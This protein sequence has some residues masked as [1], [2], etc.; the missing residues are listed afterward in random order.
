[1]KVSISLF[2]CLLIG[3][4]I[5]T[6][7]QQTISDLPR[8]CATMEQD[9][10]NKILYPQ[11]NTLDDFEESIQQRMK[12]ILTREKASGRTQALV[13]TIPVVVHVIHNGEAVGSGMNLSKAQIQSQIDVLNEDFRRRAGTPGF[14]NNPVGADIEIEFCLSPVDANG[15]ALTDPGIHRY[16]GNKTSWTREEIEGS[17]K[18]STTWNSNLF[19]N[20]WTV[21]FGG[22]SSNL[23]GYAQFPDQSGL[24]G[25]NET[26][27]SASTDGVVIQYTSF[28]SVDKGSFPIMQAPYNK[29][30]TL[31]HETGHWLGL[32]H[33]WGDGNC[34]DDFVSDTPPAASASTGCNVGRFSCGATNMV[35]N[36]MDYSNDACMNI[37]TLGQK[38]RIRAVMDLS[39]RRKSLLAANLCSPIVADVPTPDFSTENLKCV[40]LGSRVTFTDLSTNFPSE[41][42]WTFEGGD[43]GTST[44]R[45]P[46]VR[47]NSIGSFKVSL[48]AKNSL[49]ISDTL[50]V[51]DYIVVSEQGLCRDINNFKPENT[52]S[53]I[54]LAEFG[55]YTGYLTG[56]N[57]AKSKG[58][59]EFFINECGYKYISG[60]NIRFGH[61]YATSEDATV[62][63]FVWNALGPQRAPGAVIER[64]VI[65]LKQIQ[66][67]LA[68][69]K[70]TEI[71]FDRETPVFS[72]PYQVGLE[73]NYDDGD[74]LAIQ[75]S[76]DG[77]S[78]NATSWIK[79][80]ASVWSTYTIAF[81][82]N[83]AMDIEPVIGMNPSVQV[84]ASKQL[85]Y[86]GEE[87][88]LN[89]RGASIFVWNTDDG[90][91][92]NYSGPQ[93]IIR[94]TE[95]TVV[96]TNGSGLELCNKVA[97]T[98]IYVREDVTG[99]DDPLIANSVSL[100]PNPGQGSL[101]ISIENNFIG[102]VDIHILSIIGNDISQSIT[103]KKESKKLSHTINTSY[104]QPGV[105]LI[106]INLG[107]RR[108]TKKW[109]TY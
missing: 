47:Y 106:K 45:N 11:R 38:T 1:M 22:T 84:S 48:W 80:E 17:L 63:V 58:V 52:A 73:L 100:Y 29:G 66:E 24:G 13:L 9:S 25:L 105:Y 97:N 104:L 96:T 83:I 86:P 101:N 50:V 37:F 92:Q 54:K 53:T 67:D 91:V 40:L 107:G 109:I 61:V 76:L 102:D 10:I 19:Y 70:A 16:N 64:K 95:T 35:E 60:V 44:E 14:N 94:P 15:N 72:L 12:E 20:I 39:P 46:K 31:S 55:N 90:E 98:T 75:S 36:Y 8:T 78:T 42:H 85:V 7:A 23:L 81:G 69:N 5:N 93:L 65:L 43:P 68:N 57:S 77:E 79:N 87:V 32:R 103:L 89:G 74:T 41:W 6:N 30:R 62:T 2:F 99:I 82:A 33:I 49:G 34:A 4:V 28:G 71:V 56:H 21:K 108:V 3:L 59:S 51:D 88:T 18:S 26:G 27:G